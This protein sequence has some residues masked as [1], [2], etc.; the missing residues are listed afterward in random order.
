MNKTIKVLALVGK[1]LGIV[2]TLNVIPGLSPEKSVI[3]F[4]V[5]STLKDLVNRVADFL[6]DGKIND[7]IPKP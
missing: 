4:F 2:G 5:A 3:V 1:A 6:D 7:S